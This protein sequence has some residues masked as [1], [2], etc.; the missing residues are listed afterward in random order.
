MSTPYLI[1]R[2]T[3]D[4]DQVTIVRDVLSKYLA[5]YPDPHK[6][7]LQRLILHTLALYNIKGEPIPLPAAQLQKWGMDKLIERAVDD[8]WLDMPYSESQHQHRCR[9]YRPS[10][11]FINL[12]LNAYADGLPYNLMTG[13]KIRAD[14]MQSQTGDRIKMPDLARQVLR[15]QNQVIISDIDLYDRPQRLINARP[16]DHPANLG[17]INSLRACQMNF[18]LHG[19][20]VHDYRVTSTGRFSEPY[21]PMVQSRS[22][23]KAMFDDKGKLNYDLRSAHMSILADIMTHLGLSAKVLLEYLEDSDS[24]HAYARW[25]GCSVSAWKQIL[26]AMMNGA[27]VRD[28][29]RARANKLAVWQILLD[30]AEGYELLAKHRFDEL[31]NATVELRKCLRAW[32]LYLSNLQ[33]QRL[34]Q[35][36][37]YFQIVTRDGAWHLQNEV[38]LLIALSEPSSKISAHILQG[39]EA[40]FVQTLQI[41]SCRY[42]FRV[43][44]NMH[45]GL[46]STSPIPDEAVD[47]AKRITC[48]K[49]AVLVEKPF[50]ASDRDEGLVF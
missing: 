38:G 40:A 35:P 23:T 32:Q 45:D 12:W 16:A 43:E 11:D 39:V 31:V 7:K 25:I 21:G 46:V 37:P 28:D 36:N 24:K 44:N 15:L 49:S 19:G 30:D 42:G 29:Q 47:E 3:G 6:D 22:I 48:F 13:R 18:K 41:L 14:E 4:Q 34:T 8:G 1:H 17:D 27:A 50:E 9:C 2:F 33:Q 5:K 10:L 26:C 20:L